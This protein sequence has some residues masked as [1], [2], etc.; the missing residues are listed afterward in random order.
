M[1]DAASAAHRVA[2]LTEEPVLQVPENSEHEAGDTVVSP[3]LG[4]RAARALR[5]FG[6]PRVMAPKTDAWH[7]YAQNVRVLSS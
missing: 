1:Q 5:V 4:C 6:S 2:V 7:V 3:G